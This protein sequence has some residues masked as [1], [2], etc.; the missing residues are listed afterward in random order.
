MAGSSTNSYL[1]DK[2]LGGSQ[3]GVCFTGLRMPRNQD[4]LS[5][6]DIATLISWIDAGAP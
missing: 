2:V 1:V 4:Q 3:T 6:S 5:P